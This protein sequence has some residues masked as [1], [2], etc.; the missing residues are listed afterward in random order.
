[1]QRRRRGRAG[2]DRRLP[3]R[4]SSASSRTPRGQK[5]PAGLERRAGWSRHRREQRRLGPDRSRRRRAAG[6]ECRRPGGGAR[7]S[8]LP[9]TAVR[10][11]GGGIAGQGCRRRVPVGRVRLAG[12]GAGAPL[13]RILD[14][15]IAHDLLDIGDV[16]GMVDHALQLRLGL[17]R[18]PSDRSSRRR[19]R[20]CSSP[21]ARRSRDQSRCAASAP[22]R[23]SCM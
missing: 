14:P 7:A 4:A 19:S 11:L 17:R 2:C 23:S 6:A 10:W 9:L 1:M 22:A 20:H 21:T 18:R 12:C 15:D 8:A 5:R 3:A 16:A 13:G